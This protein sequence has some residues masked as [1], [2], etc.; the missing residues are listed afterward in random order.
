[1]FKLLFTKIT[2]QKYKFVYCAWNTVENLYF[3]TFP[4]LDPRN[5]WEQVKKHSVSKIVKES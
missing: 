3:L 2:C 4:V 1:M 5:L